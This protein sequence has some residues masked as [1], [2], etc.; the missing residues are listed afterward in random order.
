[1]QARLIGGNT[2]LGQTLARS[3]SAG[4]VSHAV[5]FTGPPGCGKQAWGRALAQALLCTSGGGDR[6]CGRCPSC[7]RFLS[8]NHP[9]F[10]LLEPEGRWIKI[11]QLRRLR[12]RF[13]LQGGNRVCLIREAERMTAEAAASLLKILE[14]PP[15]GLYFILLSSS[16]RQLFSTIVSRCQH[17]PLRALSCQEIED[18][19]KQE[20]DLP[21]SRVELVARLSWGLPGRALALAADSALEER[22]QEAADLGKA[23]LAGE[24]PAHKLLERAS[25]LAEREDLVLFMELLALFFRDLLVWELTGARE[26]LLDPEVI[27]G[28]RCRTAHRLEKAVLEIDRLIGIMETTNVNRRLAVEGALME[29]KRGLACG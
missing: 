21:A 29:L 19:L 28:C 27:A 20:T 4:V 9:D 15:P 14:E 8:G 10:L 23:L 18:I 24:E 17:F 25:A 22:R 26:L 6:P 7:A 3:L 13:Y 5:L 2:A 11:D 12:S 1:M 16:A